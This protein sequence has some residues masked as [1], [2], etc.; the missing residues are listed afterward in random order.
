MMKAAQ[1]F[2]A[3]N[4]PLFFN[5]ILRIMFCCFNNTL[6]IFTLHL[7]NKDHDKSALNTV[8]PV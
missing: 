2:S 1:N 3:K 8:K 6:K 7:D 5:K 4:I